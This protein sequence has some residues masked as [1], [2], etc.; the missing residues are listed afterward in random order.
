[1][2]GSDEW[3][4]NKRLTANVGLRWE[5]HV[6]WVPA[7]SHAA[8]QFSPAADFS[9]I[10]AGTWHDL[11][12]RVGAAYDL[13]GDGKTVVKAT[14]GRYYQVIDIDFANS[15]NRNTITTTTWLW[16]DLNKD[17]LYE[18]G[19]VNLDPNGAD[20]VSVAGGNVNLPASD[21]VLKMPY[22]NEYS[23]S[24]ERELAAGLAVRGLF[25][26]KHVSR[27]FSNINIL[28]PYSAWTREFTRTI[29]GPDGITGTA[30]DQGP[31]TF[32]DYDPAY[33]G[34]AFVQN[35]NTNRDSAHDDWYRNFELGLRKR[36]GGK[37]LPITASF[38]AT[39]NHRWLIGV[40]Q[41]P[42]DNLFNIDQT[43]AYTLKVNGGYELPYGVTA[44]VDF[45]AYSGVPA[46]QT[47][48]FPSS[49]QFPSSTGGLTLRVGPYGAVAAP[50]RYMTS[51]RASKTLKLRGT[52]RLR[53]DV[54]AFNLFNTNVPWSSGADP[55]ISFLE[56]PTYGL[57]SR[58]ATPRV[59][60]VGVTFAF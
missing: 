54:D 5:R 20:F 22:T 21:N 48:L 30:D 34:A 7:Q 42:N 55:S 45:S 38:L 1:M 60:R 53:I 33:R 14:F 17:G 36:A 49:G 52:Q 46:Q 28:R 18:S 13:S 32:Y 27:Q 24:V 10:D 56:G 15:L 51:A 4:L 8:G 6:N 25:V 59:G 16:H 57:I 3:R 41:S 43:W 35:Q 47:F 39:K 2:Y 40:P 23:A 11:A 9:R 58:V 37:F 12:P 50:A 19:E 44:A 29:P 26:S 31:I